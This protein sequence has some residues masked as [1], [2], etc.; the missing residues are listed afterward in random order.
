MKRFAG[1]SAV[2]LSGCGFQ[3][4]VMDVEPNRGGFVI[5]KPPVQFIYRGDFTPESQKF[6]I[7]A[8]REMKSFK[9][10]DYKFNENT[11][12]RLNSISGK[13]DKININ[14]NEHTGSNIGDQ[15]EDEND[16]E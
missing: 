10:Y 13:S 12:V 3:S 4:P 6:A 15:P 16:S 7:E 8:L 1:F 14:L 11:N 5:T 2:L 9:Y